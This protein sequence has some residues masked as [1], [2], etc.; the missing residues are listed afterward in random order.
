MSRLNP[1]ALSLPAL[2]VILLA[3]A[4]MA[5]L[6]LPGTTPARAQSTEGPEASSATV[7]GDTLEIVFDENLD[8]ASKPA[9]EAFLVAAKGQQLTISSVAIADATVTLTLS[10]NLGPTWTLYVYYTQPSSSAL[11]NA[12]GHKTASFSRQAVTNNTGTGTPSIS[13]VSIVSAP[14]FDSGGDGSKE[15]YPAGQAIVVEVTWD[16]DVTW[17][18]SASGAELQVRLQVGG[19]GASNRRLAKLVT[20]GADSGTARSLWFSYT[21]VSGDDDLNGVALAPTAEGDL[22]IAASGA[23]LKNAQGTG[24]ASR[25]HAGLGTQAGHQV[26]ATQT[27]PGNTTPTYD[28]DESPGD[29]HAPQGTLVHVDFPFNDS[30]GDPLRITM[31]WVNEIYTLTTPRFV[32][33]RVFAQ[34]R[35][36][37]VLANLPGVTSP[38]REVITVTATDTEGES[39]S[40]TMT[41]ITTFPCASFSSAEVNGKTLTLTLDDVPRAANWAPADEVLA[42]SE[43]TIMAGTAEVAVEA[44]SVS[45]A[46]ATLTLAQ[47]VAVGATVTASY[48]PRD[49]PAAVAFANESVTNSSPVPLLVS[50]TGQSQDSTSPFRISRAQPFTTGPSPAGYTLTEVSFPVTGTIAGSSLSMRIE[51]AS[52]DGGSAAPLV[53]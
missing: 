38:H 27:D 32:D 43:F 35:P 22:V 14:R 10:E 31:S 42:P 3:L 20:D 47:P 53:R 25:Q 6:L 52:R 26:D 48:T 18:V 30:D 44:V 21:V 23:T 2:P 8:P 36:N 5:A 1:Y 19:S 7:D 45:G 24:N 51:V 17:D 9:A 29:I 4:A 34:T 39:V 15:T 37:C 12:A 46:T 11:Q 13:S 40:E 50:N 41:T 16:A 28:A 33:G 49:Y